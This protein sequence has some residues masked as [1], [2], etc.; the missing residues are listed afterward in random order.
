MPL[1]GWMTSSPSD[2]AEQRGEVQQREPGAPEARFEQVAELE[3]QDH[4]ER[5][6]DD[7]EV[8][9]ARR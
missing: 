8:E 2:P 1:L 5:D 7:P 3:Q 6:V 9:E 4:V